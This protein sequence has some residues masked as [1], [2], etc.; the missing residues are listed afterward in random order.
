MARPITHDATLRSRLIEVASAMI[1]RDGPE[2]F[3][4]REVA[5]AAATSTS[6]VYSLFGSKADLITAV[7]A[8]SFASFALAQREAEPRGLRA[9]GE[10]YRAWA[11]QHPDRYRLMFSGA[12]AGATHD[13]GHGGRDPESDPEPDPELDALLPLARTLT[14]VDRVDES[15]DLGSTLAV[16]AQVH[17]AVS[18]ELARVAPPW[19]DTDAVYAAVLDA[20]AAVHPGR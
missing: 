9:L 3:S 20:I 12:V 5:G 15:V 10:A 13:G 4:V 6:A 16:W 18:L 8:D 2:R 17:G 7:V 11:L 14:G 1:D 19:I